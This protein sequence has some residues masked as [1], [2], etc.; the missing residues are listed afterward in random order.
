[1]RG[2]GNN[3]GLVTKYNLYTIPAP[4]MYGGA[5]TYLETEFPD[6]VNAWTNVVNNASVDGHAQ[7]WV[8]LRRVGLLGRFSPS[9]REWPGP[10]WGKTLTLRIRI[11]DNY[12]FLKPFMA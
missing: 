5:R 8:A 11:D 1:M 12:S 10:R 4:Q 7:G 3:F 6:V 2:G 9:G